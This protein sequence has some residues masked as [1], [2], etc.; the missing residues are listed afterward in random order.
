M[1]KKPE[2]ELLLSTNDGF[3]Y[4]VIADS[5]FE[6]FQSPRFKA[7]MPN[8]GEM[9]IESDF[10][11]DHVACLADLQQ[12]LASF[13][14]QLRQMTGK[15]YV[16]ATKYNPLHDVEPDEHEDAGFG[17]WE[18]AMVLKMY[19]ADATRLKN[20]NAID[21]SMSATVRAKQRVSFD[22]A[23]PQVSQ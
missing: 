16:I 17:P 7:L 4:E 10:F 1:D 8:A 19:L 15:R 12:L 14:N 2:Q 22:S 18:D 3:V 11:D 21:S 5:T 6:L 20:E 23:T 9:T 13:A